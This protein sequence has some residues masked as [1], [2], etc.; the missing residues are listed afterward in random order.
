MQSN[1]PNIQQA[2]QEEVVSRQTRA[3]EEIAEKYESG[4]GGVESSV[5]APTGAAYKQAAAD[6]NKQKKQMER[7]ERAEAMAANE[8]TRGRDENIIESDDED[9][10]ADEDE[11]L[12]T[13]RQNR[14]RQIK[15]AQREKVEQ[16]GK[17]HGQ[18]RE[19]L[20]DDFLKE[21]TSSDRVICHFYHRD[22]ER[23]KIMDHHLKRL[24]MRH[25]ET[26]FVKIDAEKAPF[27]VN[28]LVIR[29]MPTVC[30]FY[31]GVCKGKIIGFDGLSD[32]M[33]EGKEDE[34][35]TITLARLMGKCLIIDSEKIVDEEGIE[36]AKKAQ[37]E[38]M[39]RNVF[40]GVRGEVKLDDDEDDFNL[41]NIDDVD[42][43]F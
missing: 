25:L 21:M 26:K 14:L 17:G 6:E 2:V 29:T 34:W 40:S 13:L 36:E 23:C 37:V 32:E 42:P 12:R 27:F 24:S 43:S 1:D 31:D 9:E 5:D 18:Y 11:A 39:R 7:L 16:V 28:K 30:F 8:N 41:D 38:A 22:F 4:R 33:P 20:Q 10:G 15:R 35:P 3:L 19:I